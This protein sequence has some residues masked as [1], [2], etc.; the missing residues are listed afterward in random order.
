MPAATWPS[1]I[2]DVP[3]FP[4]PG[5]AFNDI[6]PL[7]AHR[8]PGHRDRRSCWRPPESVDWSGIEARGFIFGAPVA[9][10][11]GVGFV[12]VRKP[13]KLPRDVAVSYDLEYGTETL[14]VHADAI[15]AGP[16][17]GRRR[18]AGHRRHRRRR[19]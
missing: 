8:G 18:R 19:R 12:P 16:G 9:L 5:V 10:A 11:L 6:T 17:A 13:G 15:P 14:A 3:D 4:Q 1:L 2:V 7:L